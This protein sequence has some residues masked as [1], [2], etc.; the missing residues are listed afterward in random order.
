MKVLA[1]YLL[2]SLTGEE[3]TKE[4]IEKI[5]SSVGI[6]ADSSR[7]DTLISELSG[8]NIADV[9]AEGSAKFASVPSGGVAVGG[10]SSAAAGGAS[11]GAAAAEEEAAKESEKE[12]SDD[13]MGM[14]LFD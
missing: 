1:A 14:G 8:K 7:V 13:D 2:S 11:S 5:L 12:E 6:E 3:P 9:I 4:S 10:G